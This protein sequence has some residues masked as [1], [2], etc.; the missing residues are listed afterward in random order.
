MSKKEARFVTWDT[1]KRA[2]MNTDEGVGQVTVQRTM[3]SDVVTV[4][5]DERIELDFETGTVRV[6]KDD[7]PA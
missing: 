2:E 4:D 6:V 1:G 7:D 5:H 3:F